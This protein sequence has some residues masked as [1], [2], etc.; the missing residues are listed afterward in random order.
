MMIVEMLPQIIQ[1]LIDNLIKFV[2]SLNYEG[3]YDV[4][5]IETAD[6]KMYFVELNMR[7]GA[8]GYAVT[9]SGVN[10]P[11]MFADYMLLNK[12]IDMNVVLEDAGKTFINEKIMTDGVYVSPAFSGSKCL[13]L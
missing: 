9:Q 10:L 12:P 11:G 7:F 4:D 3:L 8:S 2:A 13:H 6:G 1:P 5:L